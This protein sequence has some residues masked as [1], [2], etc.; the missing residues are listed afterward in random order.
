MA[1]SH[2]QWCGEHLKGTGAWVSVEGL[3]SIFAGLCLGRQ[4]S[5][6]S[7]CF[8]G[9]GGVEF[10]LFDFGVLRLSVLLAY[11]LEIPASVIQLAMM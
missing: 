3:N 2:L 11:G 4:V 10:L 5:G 6:S 9:G 1:K 7:A 8:F